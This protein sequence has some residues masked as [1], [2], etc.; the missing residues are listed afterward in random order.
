MNS[1]TLYR[2][3]N[4]RQ[5]DQFWGK[6]VKDIYNTRI[7]GFQITWDNQSL[8]ERKYIFTC[9]FVFLIEKKITNYFNDTSMLI[10]IVRLKHVS[11]NIH[12][13]PIQLLYFFS[14]SK[15]R[16]HISGMHSQ[17]EFKEH[18]LIYLNLDSSFLGRKKKLSGVMLV[19]Y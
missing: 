12:S 14:Q 9:S 6:G 16:K 2:K 5:L 3:Q 15:K 7:F 4:Q 10:A 11:F 1:W 8:E 19:V 13:W 17:R 18:V